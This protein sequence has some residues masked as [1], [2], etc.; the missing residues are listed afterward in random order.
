LLLDEQRIRE[1]QLVF[2]AWPIEILIFN[3]RA[4][5]IELLQH[6]LFDLT[7]IDHVSRNI[8]AFLARS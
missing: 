6:V 4:G 2:G 7:V 5:S 3:L 1:I 8:F